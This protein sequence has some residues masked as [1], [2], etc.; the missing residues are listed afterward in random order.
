MAT[1]TTSLKRFKLLHFL[2]ILLLTG[3]NL[4]DF[5]VLNEYSLSNITTA[6]KNGCVLVALQPT[7]SGELTSNLHKLAEAFKN[8][9]RARIGVL[10]ISD[11]RSISWEN[12][13]NQDVV[14]HEDLAFFPRKIADRT[15]LIQPTWEKTLKA[16]QYH[17]SRTLQK[18][19]EFINTKCGTFRQLDG[20][21]SN[22]GLARKRILENLYRVPDNEGPSHDSYSGPV[23][24][25]S[26]CE[27]I[28][29]PSKEKFFN[30]FFF[31]AKPVVITGKIMQFV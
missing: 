25:G 16:H 26:S 3:L 17:G 12:S 15:C 22:A 5:K 20:S 14:N 8:E 19:L 13:R 4:A 24:I 7:C 27:R 29:L 31:R 9:T 28:P 18:L 30:E 23:N 1:S 11:V 6:V 10:K 2:Y 21:L